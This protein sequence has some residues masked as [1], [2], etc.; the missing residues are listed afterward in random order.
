MLFRS[1]VLILLQLIEQRFPLLLLDLLRPLLILPQE[2]LVL[3]HDLQL[4]VIG[5]QLRLESIDLGIAVDRQF[6][7]F[8]CFRRSAYQCS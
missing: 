6:Q 5:P 2:N 7:D 1:K 8:F 3:F 4:G